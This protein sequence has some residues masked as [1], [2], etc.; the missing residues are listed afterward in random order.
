M[1]KKA[2]I[3]L[4][5]GL[6]SITILALAKQQGFLCYALSFNYG[7]RHNAELVVAKKIAR[8]YQVLEHKIIEL[9]L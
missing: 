8:D 1:S 2:I 6:D 4:S 5:G 3:L 7:Q 9:D